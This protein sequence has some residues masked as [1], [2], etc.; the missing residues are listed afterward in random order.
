[1]GKRFDYKVLVTGLSCI[2]IVVIRQLGAF[3][4]T[5]RTN[6]TKKENFMNVNFKIFIWLKTNWADKNTSLTGLLWHL[7]LY[8]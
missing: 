3:M 7:S 4:K 8:S 2:F 6:R 5:H 1:M